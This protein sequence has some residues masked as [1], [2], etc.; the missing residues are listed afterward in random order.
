MAES[1]ATPSQEP[2]E[3]IPLLRTSREQK[4]S[5]DHYRSVID[6][7]GRVVTCE[8]CGV[9]LDPIAVLS[10]LADKADH[11]VHVLEET[12]RLQKEAQDL[13]HRIRL[14]KGRLRTQQRAMGIAHDPYDEV[15]APRALSAEEAARWTAHSLAP[16]GL[17]A[18]DLAQIAADRVVHCILAAQRNA[19]ERAKRATEHL[20]KQHIDTQGFY[21]LLDALD[22]EIA[23]GAPPPAGS[24][25]ATHR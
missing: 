3:I 9:V 12:R 1:D 5:C 21:E 15:V 19:L 8:M 13:D 6:P 16:L 10:R 14:L 11:Y 2:A 4:R 17:L 18:G 25:N 23:A 24:Q 7:R 20:A 22:R